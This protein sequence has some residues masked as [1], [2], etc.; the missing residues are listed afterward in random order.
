MPS[1]HPAHRLRAISAPLGSGGFVDVA[2]GYRYYI[3]AL[4]PTDQF[5]ATATVA[6]WIGHS[7]LISGEY[8]GAFGASSSDT[9]YRALYVKTPDG[10]P[11]TTSEARPYTTTDQI[12]TQSLSPQI[13][14]RID[15]HFDVMAGSSHTF[16][17]KNALHIDR[18]YVAIALR[19][20]KLGPLQG[21]MGGRR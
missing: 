4:S 19:Q 9:S 7:L 5:L 11:W 8:D 13:L 16:S 12:M 10:R 2:G 18:V 1:R 14:Y 20:T 21:F 15:D 6:Y 3:D 17:A